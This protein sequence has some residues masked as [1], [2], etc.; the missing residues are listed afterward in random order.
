MDWEM[1]ASQKRRLKQSSILM[2]YFIL[3][4]DHNFSQIL[5]LLLA[6]SLQ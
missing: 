2:R 1:K 6:L 5:N 4:K 3:K